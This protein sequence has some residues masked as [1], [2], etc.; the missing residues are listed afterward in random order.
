V[1]VTDTTLTVA[2]ATGRCGVG[3]AVFLRPNLLTRGMGVDRETADRSAWVARMFAVRDLAVGVG[4]LWAVRQGSGLLSGG[5][6][7]GRG[8]SRE[9]RAM[10]LLG[11]LCDAGDAI[12]VG[13]ALRGGT[14]SA[15]PA[16]ATL[17]TAVGAAATGAVLAAR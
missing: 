14:V 7:L 9:L 16:A 3:A 12:A 4:V 6:L 17:A 11:V 15:L 2:L 5:G 10:L 13:S 8:T 1:H